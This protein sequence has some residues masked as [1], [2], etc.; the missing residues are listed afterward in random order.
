VGNAAPFL[1]GTGVIGA[2]VP[3]QVTIVIGIGYFIIDRCFGNHIEKWGGEFLLRMNRTF[4]FGMTNTSMLN[5]F[6]SLIC[7]SKLV[8]ARLTPEK[9]LDNYRQF[10]TWMWQLPDFRFKLPWYFSWCASKNHV[11]VCQNKLATIL[12]S[13]IIPEQEMTLEFLLSCVEKVIYRPMKVRSSNA[14]WQII[15]ALVTRRWNTTRTLWE[16]ESGFRNQRVVDLRHQLRT[17]I[18]ENGDASTDGQLAS[19][20]S[21]KLL[22]RIEQHYRDHNKTIPGEDNPFFIV[23]L[24]E[25]ESNIFESMFWMQ[26][27]ENVF[28]D[29]S[30]AFL[31]DN[32]INPY[33]VVD[34]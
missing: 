33:K 28:R 7:S 19:T 8:E 2:F 29:I 3:Y 31:P 5:Y 21:A 18:N 23:P 14:E 9:R 4:L 34:N 11:G 10:I 26:S 25:N 22:F 32:I 12:A 6:Y 16:L 1:F 27:V 20:V 30:G 13:D 17:E 24:P 15:E